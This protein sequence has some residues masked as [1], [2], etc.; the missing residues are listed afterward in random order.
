MRL[1]LVLC[2]L[3]CSLGVVACWS[4]AVM[5]CARTVPKAP[6]VAAALPAHGPAQKRAKDEALL[7]ADSPP[8][9]EQPAAEP[10]DPWTPPKP[11]P[12]PKPTGPL[13]TKPQWGLIA[14]KDGWPGWLSLGPPPVF[15]PLAPKGSALGAISPD[16]RRAAFVPL[17]GTIIVVDFSQRKCIWIHSGLGTPLRECESDEL[18]DPVKWSPD[19]RRIA[20]WGGERLSVADLRGNMELIATAPEEM[21]NSVEWSPDA[22]LVAYTCKRGLCLKRVGGGPERVLIRGD[23]WGVRWSPDGGILAAWVSDKHEM[24]LLTPDGTTIAGWADPGDRPGANEPI[25]G[26]WLK[27]GS[28]FL[29]HF[30]GDSTFRIVNRKGARRKLDLKDP[31]GGADVLPD[32]RIFAAGKTGLLRLLTGEGRL[33]WST[34]LPGGEPPLHVCFRPDGKVVAL[35]FSPD[36]RADSKRRSMIGRVGEELTDLGLSVDG[37]VGWVWGLP[38]PKPDATQWVAKPPKGWNPWSWRIS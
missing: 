23:L 22:K 24:R 25:S 26:W 11:E 33:I 2:V 16:G 30:W 38:P 15:V 1:F 31:V 6:S 7:A 21:V 28:A 9:D 3:V 5:G 18:A 14:Y 4:G 34:T 17:D 37:I 20:Y 27:D 36:A 19:G 35:S 12:P 13:P 32:G 10:A 29:Y 8:P